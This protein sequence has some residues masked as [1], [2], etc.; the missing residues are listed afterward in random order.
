MKDI[1]E[2]KNRWK[3]ILL[4]FLLLIVAASILYTN[5]I[6]GKLANE[7]R[8]KME[9]LADTYKKLNEADP[10]SDL[11]FMFHII[12]INETVPV[13]VT[14]DHDSIQTWRNLDSNKVAKDH[15]YLRHALA[16]MKSQHAPIAIT[17]SPNAHQYIYYYDSYLLTALRYF[18]YIQF[19]II[20][21]FLFVAYLLF[22]TSRR[23]EQNRV[24][25][26]MAKETAHQLG[27]PISA[28]A[29]WV[30]HMKLTLGDHQAAALIPDVERDINRL[31]LIAQRFSK[32]GSQ[33]DLA[34]MDVRQEIEKNIQYIK[35]RASGRVTMNIYSDG[36]PVRALINAP[37]FDWVLENLMKNALDAI[38]GAGSI[39]FYLQTQ[40]RHAIIDVK[41]TGKGIPPSKIKAVFR[42]GFSTKKRGWGL[43]LSL[44]KRII[45]EYHRGKIFVKESQ[46]NKGTTFR[47][48]LNVI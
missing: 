28:L 2:Q 47:I 38:G 14:D 3:I 36:Q 20:G 48:I 32:I 30:E 37:L 12:E 41:D 40:G 1:Y 45:E 23:S 19:G 4:F 26:G 29:G 31:E 6:A 11:S 43:G 17:Y 39:D 44:A 13:I 22:S 5:Y 34:L 10:N 46:I 18:P 35:R 8:S 9:L 27:T 42:P 15:S 16:G 21:I 24:W 7:E 25:V 33:P